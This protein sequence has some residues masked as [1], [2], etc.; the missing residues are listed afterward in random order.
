MEGNGPI[1][2]SQVGLGERYGSEDMKLG[3]GNRFSFERD[4]VIYTDIIESVHYSSG[5][6]AV[7]R[8]LNHW[9]RMMR[10]VTPRRW[11]KTLLIR[12]AALPSMTINGNHAPDLDK[13]LKNMKEVIDLLS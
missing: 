11:R 7:Y 13:T 10:R 9:Q 2:M 8:R 3:L 6:P 12:P 5:S 4:G 1:D